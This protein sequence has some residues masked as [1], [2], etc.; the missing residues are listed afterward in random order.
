M[1]GLRKEHAVWLDYSVDD[2]KREG[3]TLQQLLEQTPSS[4][5]CWRR[6]LLGQVNVLGAIFERVVAPPSVL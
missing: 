2:F 4:D 5:R 6:E 3:D 1:D